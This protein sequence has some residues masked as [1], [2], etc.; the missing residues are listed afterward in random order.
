MKLKGTP[1]CD[2]CLEKVYP[3]ELVHFIDGY[4]VCPAC[5][6]DFAFDYFF[7]CLVEVPAHTKDRLRGEP[8]TEEEGTI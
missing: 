5:F 7:D 6:L 2:R 8:G 4:V 1:R 3:G